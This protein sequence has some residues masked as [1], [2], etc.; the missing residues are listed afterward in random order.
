MPFGFIINLDTFL[1]LI[2]NFNLGMFF[3]FLNLSSNPD[4]ADIRYDV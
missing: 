2:F 4:S 1:Q 3:G